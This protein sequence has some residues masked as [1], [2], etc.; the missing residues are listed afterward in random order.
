MPDDVDD[1]DDVYV[2]PDP[3]EA[4]PVDL[5][6]AVGDVVPWGTVAFLLA[7]GA[8]FVTFALQG[9]F[10]DRRAL[11]AWGASLTGLPA[12]ESA[13]RLLASTF[14]HAGPG[15][16]L[17]N[18]VSLLIFGPT[19]E[20]L[21]PR[22][23]FWIVYTLGGAAAS[24]GSLAWRSARHGG[25]ESLSIGGSGAVFA[26]G[27]AVLVASLRLRHVIP[28]GRARALGASVLFLM[29]PGFTSG[30]T[31]NATDNAGHAAGLIAGMLLGAM[32]PLHEQLGGRPRT[33]ITQA[34]GVLAALALAFSFVWSVVHGLGVH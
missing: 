9:A 33:G 17:S 10:D 6:A 27:G 22:W 8:V 29:L 34:V 2:P 5:W 7:W 25:L 23:G 18:A 19:V 31:R 28:A 32:V 1:V 13:W 20:R 24:L 15:H 4:P 30:F 26:L 12:A 21:F 11:I 16:V 14:L 3:D